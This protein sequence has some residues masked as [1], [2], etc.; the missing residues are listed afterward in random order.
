MEGMLFWVTGLAGAGKTTLGRILYQRLRTYYP[1]TIFLDGDCLRKIFGGN[2][3][4]T[5]EE[6]MKCAFCYSRLCK[7]LV[8]QGM[9]VVCATISMFDEVRAWNRCHI[10]KYKEIYVE[11]SMKILEERNQHHLYED[12]RSGK[13]KNVAGIDVEVEFPKNPDVHIVNDGSSNPEKMVEDILNILQL[14]FLD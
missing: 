6:R 14:S 12:V 3:G 1:N 5:R 10:T 9:Y 11:A 2:M 4:Y 13:I 7:L 8:D